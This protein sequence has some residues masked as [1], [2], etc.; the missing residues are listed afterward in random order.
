MKRMLCV[1]I[2]AAAGCTSPSAPSQPPPPPN[3]IFRAV[4]PLEFGQCTSPNEDTFNCEAFTFQIENIGQGCALATEL[5]G[6]I[7]LFLGDG[8]RSTAQWELT[9]DDRATTYFRPGE[10][11]RATRLSGTLSMTHVD[12]SWGVAF[13]RWTAVACP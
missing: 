6:D 4:G 10:K 13:T 11:K 8:M 3:P 1:S 2:F 7:T 9:A 5:Q 12:H